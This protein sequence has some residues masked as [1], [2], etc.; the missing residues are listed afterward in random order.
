MI[1]RGH[2]TSRDARHAETRGKTRKNAGKRVETQR[3]S[4]VCD[5]RVGDG[6]SPAELYPVTHDALGPSCHCLRC[7]EAAG[8]N[9]SVPSPPTG[10]INAQ[11]QE[12]EIEPGLLMLDPEKVPARYKVNAAPATRGSE[13]S[14]GELVG[15]VRRPGKVDVLWMPRPHLSEYYC[16]NRAVPVPCQCRAGPAQQA[17]SRFSTAEA[18]PCR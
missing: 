14:D 12:E 10:P 1:A 7:L 18:K 17:P 16:T 8:V 3:N 9:V 15:I 6:G 5:G 11:L 13:W 4:L 2:R